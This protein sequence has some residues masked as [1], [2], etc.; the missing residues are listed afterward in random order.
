LTNVIKPCNKAC[1]LTNVIKPCNAAQKAYKV[2]KVLQQCNA[3][4]KLTSCQKC[5]SCKMQIQVHKAW[6]LINNLRV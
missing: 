1:V 4:Q 5:S 3:V 2:T 6:M